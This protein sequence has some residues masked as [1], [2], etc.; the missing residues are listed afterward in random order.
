MC[1]GIGK[2]GPVHVQGQPQV[3]GP[4]AQCFQFIH[5]VA[6]THFGGLSDTDHL[7]FGVVHVG[8]APNH[9]F[10]RVGLDLTIGAFD[11]LHLGAIG[12]ELRGPAFIPFHMGEVMAEDA[13]VGLAH[14]SQ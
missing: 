9:G 8:A 7:G 6:G 13:V 1:H 4:A 2:A 3:L 12:K 11:Q 10:Y 14:G 5:R